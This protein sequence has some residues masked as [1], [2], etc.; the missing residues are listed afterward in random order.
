MSDHFFINFSMYALPPSPLKQEIKCRKL[1]H[2]DHISFDLDLKNSPLISDSPDDLDLLCELYHDT[3]SELLDKNAPST[4]KIVSCKKSPWYN[5]DV[6]QTKN[7]R[8]IAERQWRHSKLEIHRQIFNSAK[9]HTTSVI[10]KAKS[11]YCISKI[12]ENSHSP[13]F[14]FDFV[15]FSYGKRTNNHPART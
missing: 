4:T 6:H 15:F 10:R 12:E 1:K 2:I 11:E 8:R 9:S 14:L 3:L 13:K 5:E 7:K